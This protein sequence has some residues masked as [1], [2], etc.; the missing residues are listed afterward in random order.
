MDHLSQ[1]YVARAQSALNMLA[2]EDARTPIQRGA[3]AFLE[4]ARVML[5]HRQKQTALTV[6]QAHHN[7][8]IQ[9]AS[10][11]IIDIDGL[12]AGPQAQ[13]LAENYIASISQRSLLD[14]LLRFARVIPKDL[15]HVLIASDSIGNSVTEGS[16]KPTMDL[17]LNLQDT[18]PVKSVALIVMSNELARHTSEAGRKMF[19]DELERAVVRAMNQAVL[20]AFADS[21]SS[22]VA[23]GADALASLR[24]GL[25]ALGGTDAA[26]VAVNQADAAWLATSSSNSGGMGLRGGT[27]VPGV[28]IVTVD[29]HVGMTLF[30]A[31]RFGLWDGGLQVKS[32]GETAIDMR[33][34]PADPYEMVS[35]FQTDS[36]AVMAERMWQIV[37]PADGIVSVEGA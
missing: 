2:G 5:Q 18:V 25:A 22:T 23:A 24:A 15:R 3:D 7:E 32:S 21:G 9:K 35:M 28:E 34:S 8:A 19:A 33:A 13:I 29:D 17:S 27:F 26:V 37:G 16:P 12:F 36:T 31:S 6:L 4:I 14:Q 1:A 10:A 20:T 30:P 11:H